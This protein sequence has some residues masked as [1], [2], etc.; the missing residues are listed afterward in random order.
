MFCEIYDEIIYIRKERDIKL[1]KLEC[2]NME[3]KKKISRLKVKIDEKDVYERKDMVIV[4][5][6]AIPP[7]NKEENCSTLTSK[8]IKD[9]LNYVVSPND[10]SG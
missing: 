1:D 2:K 10:I 8:L 7:V 6:N 9:H 4:F 5:G 3:M